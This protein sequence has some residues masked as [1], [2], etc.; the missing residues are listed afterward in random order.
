MESK[1]RDLIKLVQA[2]PS[3]R[4]GIFSRVLGQLRKDNPVTAGVTTGIAALSAIV[5]MPIFGPVGAIS[6][7]GWQVVCAVALGTTAVG[8]TDKLVKWWAAMSDED[9]KRF[10]NALAR[11]E[12]LAKKQVITEEEFQEMAKELYETS[13][14]ES[15]KTRSPEHVIEAEWKI[16]DPPARER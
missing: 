11:L 14:R 13:R 8:A 5:A 2:S 10:L 9:H 6:Y 7:A 15:H 3:E 4:E 12:M 1:I 16:V